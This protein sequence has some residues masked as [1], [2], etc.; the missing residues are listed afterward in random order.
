MLL[1]RCG[2]AGSLACDS[3]NEIMRSALRM[4]CSRDIVPR[5]AS[6]QP[7]QKRVIWSDRWPVSR[8]VRSDS[9][10]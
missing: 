5:F 9:M 3:V 2:N 4:V 6:S 10:M 8:R 1:W 7:R